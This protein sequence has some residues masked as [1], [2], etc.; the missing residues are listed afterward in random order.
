M[1]LSSITALKNARHHLRFSTVHIKPRI[2][3]APC[4]YH[5]FWLKL[6]ENSQKKILN[7]YHR[8]LHNVDRP[9]IRHLHA[10]FLRTIVTDGILFKHHTCQQRYASPRAKST[11]ACLIALVR[12]RSSL[13][14]RKMIIEVEMWGV[15]S[16]VCLMTGTSTILFCPVNQK[17]VTSS[18]ISSTAVSRDILDVLIIDIPAFVFLLYLV[19]RF[20]YTKLYF[21]SKTN[22]EESKEPCKKKRYCPCSSVL[23]HCSSAAVVTQEKIP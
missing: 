16:S 14:S 15:T 19:S 1:E 6:S 11:F 4:P 18:W 5:L 9:Y 3:T 21:N 17:T 23:S 7:L 10:G 20:G 22:H 12:R 2:R 8:P 13:R